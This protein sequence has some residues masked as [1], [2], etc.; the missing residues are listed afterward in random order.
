MTTQQ[1]QN[2][3]DN[4]QS[5]DPSDPKA[6]EKAIVAFKS[7]GQ[8]PFFILDFP[9]LPI[10]IF[11]TRTHDTNNYFEKFSDI[12][13]P[14]RKFV[15]SFG[16][17]NIPHQ[18][19][20][21]C[22]DIR[23]TSYLELLE[24]WIEEKKEEF[25]YATIGKWTI[26]N[27]LKLLII[28]SP[29]EKDR[30]SPYDKMYGKKLDHFINQ[31]NGD[32]KNAIIILYKFL[33]DKFRKPAKKDPQTYIITAAYSNFAF[34]MT[35]DSVDGILYPSV[36]SEEKGIN[37]AIKGTYNFEKN[38]KLILVTRDTFRRIDKEPLPKFQEF[39]SKQAK[40]IDYCKKKIIWH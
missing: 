25:L 7:M 22:S 39:E 34:N 16:R 12:A 30:Q 26:E 14:N 17:C 35:K 37:L 11:H 20:F 33:F 40:N 28:T 5:I 31:Q 3:I 2:S 9:K 8:L 19:V 4:L 24:Y 1:V 10:N 23:P 38:M 6:Y 29:S 18:P 13:I 36:P 27:S 15:K 21:Y 32:M